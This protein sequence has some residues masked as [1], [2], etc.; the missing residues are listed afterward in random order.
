[1]QTRKSFFKSPLVIA[2]LGCVLA[3]AVA[4]GDDDDTNPAPGSGGTKNTGGSGGSKTGGSSSTAGTNA[5]AGAGNE[6]NTGNT[7]NTGSGGEGNQPSNGDAGMAGVGTGGAAPD[8]VDETDRGC[9]SCAPK[10]LEQFLNACPT[11]G[12]EPFDNTSL[13]SLPRDGKLPDLP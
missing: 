13:G 9:Y 5:N 2:S 11:D 12:C 7:G 6:G 8:C 10:T 4:C 1:M 3:F